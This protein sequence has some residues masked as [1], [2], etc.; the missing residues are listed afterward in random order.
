MCSQHSERTYF[1]ALR[2]EQAAGLNRPVCPR[3]GRPSSPSAHRRGRLPRYGS[4][5]DYT[6]ILLGRCGSPPGPTF[7]PWAPGTKSRQ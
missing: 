6:T 1:D 4:P 7:G 5:G 2:N 3:G